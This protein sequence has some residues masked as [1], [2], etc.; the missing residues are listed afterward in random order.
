MEAA[1]FHPLGPLVE[2]PIDT[3]WARLWIT[4]SGS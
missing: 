3:P 1:S 4:A 2:N